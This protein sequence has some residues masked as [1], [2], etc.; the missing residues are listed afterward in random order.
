MFP[1]PRNAQTPYFIGFFA[2]PPHSDRACAKMA[3]TAPPS[4]PSSPP[5]LRE[6]G[7]DALGCVLAAAGYVR[8]LGTANSLE[9]R[10]CAC[11]VAL[12]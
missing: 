4:P 8:T 9:W 6:G 5:P 1:S 7:W 12:R 11:A 2:P 10:F 3:L